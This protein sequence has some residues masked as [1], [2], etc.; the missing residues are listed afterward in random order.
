ML[1]R[2][3]RT[4]RA[5]AFKRECILPCSVHRRDGELGAVLDVPPARPQPQRGEDV[6]TASPSGS[7]HGRDGELGA[8]LDAPPARP[9]PQRGADVQTAS[10]SGSVHGRDDEPGAVLDAPPARPQPQRGAARTCR[11]Q[12][13][14]AQF[15]VGMTNPAPSLMSRPHARSRSAAR[16]CRQQARRAQFIVGMTNSAPSLMPDGQRE[17]T[18]LVLV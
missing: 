13:R 18:V 10:P 6:Q 17:V 4:Q 11:Q 16:T 8:V 2:C 3:W 7:V 5:R 9:Q 1:V 15:I 12:A 14:R